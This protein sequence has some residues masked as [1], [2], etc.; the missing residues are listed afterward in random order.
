MAATWK[1][2]PTG[3]THG[4]KIKASRILSRAVH[5]P[6]ACL[7]FP[8]CTLCSNGLPSPRGLPVAVSKR[9]TAAKKRIAS[10]E[11]HSAHGQ[12]RPLVQRNTKDS[13]VNSNRIV[14]S[15]KL[16]QKCN[17]HDG[18]SSH[19]NSSHLD[20]YSCH[21]DAAFNSSYLLSNIHG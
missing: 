3:P 19:N 1:A 14:H 4:G 9:W 15:S 18:S 13:H 5:A 2:A 21:W 10:D 7:F 16:L 6:T 20:N 11:D 17:F 8:H 12:H